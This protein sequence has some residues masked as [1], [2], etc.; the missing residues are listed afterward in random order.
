MQL[1]PV[2]AMLAA[3]SPVSCERHW[4]SGSGREAFEVRPTVPSTWLVTPSTSWPY[5]HTYLGQ[6]DAA[7]QLVDTLAS[8]ALSPP[9]V[10]DVLCPGLN[11]QIAFGEGA[12]TQAD[13]FA[14]RAGVE[15]PARL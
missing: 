11:S 9:P 14:A 3:P 12:L 1:A 13:V 10:T 8:S 15:P 2:N 4:P 7:R 5:C 6:F